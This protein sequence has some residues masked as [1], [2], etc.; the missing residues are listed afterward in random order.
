MSVE[1]SQLL[2]DVSQQLFQSRRSFRLI[3]AVVVGVPVLLLFG[4]L[5]V[6]T[7]YTSRAEAAR[8]MREQMV[9]EVKTRAKTLNHHIAMMSRYPDQIALA[10]TIRKPDSVDALLSFQYAMLAEYPMIYG[11]AIAWEPF[12]F[13]PK[14]EYVSP[15][16]WRDVK[17][18]GA[19]SNMLFTPDNGYNYLSGKWDWYEHPKKKYGGDAETPPPLAFTNGDTEYAKLP[20]IESGLW[21][22][23][24]FDEGGGNVLMCTY[25]APFF[26]NRR[27]AGVVTC[28]ITTD[29]I[30]KF[31]SEQAFKGGWFV[32]VSPEG[33][34]ISHHDERL[35]MKH[36]THL[37]ET[38]KDSDRKT[39]FEVGR[40]IFERFDPNAFGNRRLENEGTY[41]PELSLTLLSQQ[42]SGKNLWTEGIQLPTTGWVLICVVPEETVYGGAVAD[43]QSTMFLF[44][45]G[46]LLFG[47]YLFWQVDRRIIR[48]LKRLVI[49]TN[50]VADGNFEHQIAIGV[51]G[52]GELNEVSHNF[53]RMIRTLRQSIADAVRNASEKE[54]AEASN[55]AKSAFLANMSH[56][57][58]TPMNGVI[59][60][61]DLLART[62]LNELQTEY[63]SYIR[64]SAKSLLTII[65]DVLDISKVEAGKFTLSIY[66]FQPR[67]IFE[68]V[69]RSLEFAATEKNL[70]FPQD[71][72]PTLPEILLGDGGRFRQIL[73]NIIGNALKFT[74]KGSVIVRCCEE[75]DGD[76]C[77]LH[78]EITD[79]G[80][81]IAP[82]FLPTLFEPFAQADS[83]I[84]RK[85][86]GTGLGLTIVKYLVDHMKGTIH[87]ESEPGKG[88]NFR[89]VIP[90]DIPAE[91]AKWSRHESSFFS[92]LLPTRPLSILLVEDV[93]INV[94][95]ATELLQTMGHVITVAEN[96]AVALDQLRNN[97][98]DIVLMDCQMPI[99]D[100]YQCVRAIR[101][102]DSG[103]RNPAIPVIA[104][105]AH[106]MSGD[107]EKCL[108]AGMDDYIS[109]PID[110]KLLAKKLNVHAQ[111]TELD[112]QA[113]Q[114]TKTPDSRSSLR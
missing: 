87:V 3:F 104:M 23:P 44:L 114:W 57:I 85:F 91:K 73:F 79:T 51:R 75:S 50:A 6:Q 30:G 71:L 98:F 56:E 88:T 66:P 67:E 106:A 8:N 109:K 107:R 95:V 11:N 17:H 110:G 61:A 46:V 68:D 12:L 24:Y 101:R 60:L 89:F 63:L 42:Q 80:V 90:F 14:E 15:Y 25:S 16:V 26:L 54:A 47:V 70:D 103:V 81:G 113:R 64:S 52:S 39:V 13:D 92:T 9:N 97:D 74:A 49:A 108:D 36:F 82:E 32:L 96:G 69:C 62:P 102:P 19:V 65:N 21:S 112:A 20:R 83:S 111:R 22:V 76:R 105:T 34:I 28:D 2:V 7:Y 99:M 41:C 84:T 94:L 27:F 43:F 78:C 48:P 58:R 40:A 100:G 10:I 18:G 38:T 45:C 93:K 5:I 31:L 37:A 53:N 33:F 1:P 72:S 77:R 59:G 4:I 86:G 55:R 35:I 29:W